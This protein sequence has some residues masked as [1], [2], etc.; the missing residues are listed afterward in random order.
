MPTITERILALFYTPTVHEQ[1]MACFKNLQELQ[2]RVQ[3]AEPSG[4][5]QPLPTAHAEY[6]REYARCE[7]I[8]RME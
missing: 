7:P 1:R 6:K 3:K 5:D 2:E 8:M 4:K